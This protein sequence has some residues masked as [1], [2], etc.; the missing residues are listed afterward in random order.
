MTSTSHPPS[1]SFGAA[2]S[3]AAAEEAVAEELRGLETG[4]LDLAK[5]PHSEHVRLGYEMLGRHSFGDVVARFGRGLKL[6]AAKAGKPQ[7]YH[8]T[9][10]VAFLALINE[11]RARGASRG[12]REFEDAN[13][14]LFDKRCLE[15]WYGAEQL[16][17][18]LARRIFC[19]P[20]KNGDSKS[21]SVGTGD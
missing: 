19:L 16:S 18:D 13:P 1:D 20:S 8:E 11:R 21:P 14:D 12:W 6:L 10:T 7:V 9:I 17:S 3:E 15:K 5:F 4:A 2:G